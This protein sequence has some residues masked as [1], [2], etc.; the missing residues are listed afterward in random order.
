MLDDAGIFPK[1]L[2][3]HADEAN[4]I[5]WVKNIALMGVLAMLALPGYAVD[6]FGV[7]LAQATRD[8]L[9][10][11]VKNAG[12]KL[13]RQAGDDTFYDVYESAEILH[14]SNRLYL[15]FVKGDNR[16]A[17]AEYEFPGLQQPE[18]QR[19]LVAKYGQPTVNS[20]KFMTDKVYLWQIDSVRIR[21]HADWSMHKTRLVYFIPA[22]L[23]QLHGEQ[24]NFMIG[25]REKQQL[26]LPQGY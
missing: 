21:L 6:L 26:Y 23:E 11:A 15:G 10:N 17:F 4:M 3:R 25:L 12:V 7:N 13:V 8:Q 19:R 1:A 2:L 5:G 24:K 18:M 20:G 22:A 9:R 14:G 16:F